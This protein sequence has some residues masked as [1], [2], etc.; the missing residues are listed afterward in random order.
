MNK[1]LLAM[2]A[3]A[4]IC[5]T[6]C[7][8]VHKNDGGESDLRTCRV[9]DRVYEKFE[10]S[11]KT[12]SAT[13]TMNCVLGLIRWG[14]TASHIADQ[15]EFSGFGPV[16]AVKN[17]AYAK[18]CE[19][20]GCDQIAAARYTLT[21]EDYFVFAKYVSFGTSAGMNVAVGMY[22]WL[23]LDRIGQSYTMFCAGGVIVAI[24]VTILFMCLQKYYVEGVT[25]GAV[26]G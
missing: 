9:K 18:A 11:D 17:G 24:P 14:Q 21:K 15:A 22:S 1:C 19:A 23:Q 8:S 26:K 5:A 12:V 2:T 20:A 3:V 25:G 6:G 16:A 10:V 4:A 7:I 13:E